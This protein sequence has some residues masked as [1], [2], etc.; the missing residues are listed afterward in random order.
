MMQVK[1]MNV[2]TSFTSLSTI[3]IRLIAIQV[4]GS[5]LQAHLDLQTMY[6]VIYLGVLR[7]KNIGF[8]TVFITKRLTLPHPPSGIITID[9][10]TDKKHLLASTLRQ[11]Q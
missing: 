5:Y 11:H 10:R 9:G 6:N 2:I 4:L 1:F 8:A 3:L 7:I